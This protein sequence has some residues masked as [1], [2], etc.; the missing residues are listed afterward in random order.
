MMSDTACV[1]DLLVEIEM[2]N[3]AR[4]LWD[5]SSV[6]G[7]FFDLQRD[8]VSRMSVLGANR[9]PAFVRQRFVVQ[10]TK[11]Q[12]VVRPQMLC[13]AAAQRVEAL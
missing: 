11:V 4:C 6:G 13:R 12:Y 1:C 7:P 9:V 5:S 3:I 8:R 10:L 2:S